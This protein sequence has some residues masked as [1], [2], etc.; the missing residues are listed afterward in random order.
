MLSSQA[1]RLRVSFA[2]ISF[3]YDM[4]LPAKF[5]Q[6]LLSQP[7]TQGLRNFPTISA[8][9]FQPNETI[10]NLTPYLL[11]DYVTHVGLNQP[12]K[13]ALKTGTLFHQTIFDKHSRIHNNQKGP[14][15]NRQYVC[16]PFILLAR[17]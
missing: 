3:V 6:A 8:L 7:A 12:I 2:C 9:F 11:S 17:T 4:R 10:V 14:Y 13:F 16:I 5:A 1:H 15:I